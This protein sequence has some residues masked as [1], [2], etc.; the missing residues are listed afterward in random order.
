MKLNKCIHLALAVSF[1]FFATASSSAAETVDFEVFA[2]GTMLYSQVPGVLFSGKPLVETY[3][4]ASSGSRVLHTY[5]PGQEFHTGP[6]VI[7]FT[8][9]QDYV[10]LNAGLV[11]PSSIP[12]SATL[13]AYNSLGFVV[14]TD[15]A[16]VPVGPSDFN[17]QL[18][19]TTSTPQI[20][21]IELQY[22]GSLFEAIDDL[23]I[24]NQGPPAPQDNVAPQVTITD[25]VNGAVV[26]TEDFLF[27]ADILE[28]NLNFAE[29]T[30][31]HAGN[32]STFRVS[33][34]GPAPDHQVGPFWT[35]DLGIGSNTVT[36]TAVDLS[37]NTTNA[38]IQVERAAVEAELIVDTTIPWVIP[39]TPG[40]PEP[41]RVEVA[42]TFPG[43]LDGSTGITVEAVAPSMV[44][45][46]T[47]IHSPGDPGAFAD[48]ELRA[49]FQAPLGSTTVTLQAVDN[50]TGVVLDTVEIRASL[51][52]SN[53]P[54]CDDLSR[55]SYYQLVDRQELEDELN[56]TVDFKLTGLGVAV[57]DGAGIDPTIPTD[58]DAGMTLTEFTSREAFVDLDGDG[59]YSVF[60]PVYADADGSG[61]VNNPDQRLKHAPTSIVGSF[62]V[63]GDVD[64]G[65]LLTPFT[66]LH[67][68]VDL[69]N[70]GL[71]D[72][73]L[74]EP[75]Y[76][77]SANPAGIVS[78]G[79]LRMAD[80]LVA[81]PL[82]KKT[83][84]T[85]HYMDYA[86]TNDG[87]L[88]VSQEFWAIDGDS[89]ADVDFIGDL[90]IS[91]A[92]RDITFAYNYK[93][94]AITGWF[95]G[96]PVG[97]WHGS[98][99]EAEEQF[100]NDFALVLRDELGT[101]M[102]DRINEQQ[103]N[104]TTFLNDGYFTDTEFGLGFCLPGDAFPAGDD[105]PS[106]S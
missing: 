18:V 42:E 69:N 40:T 71:L 72:A 89:Q 24:S 39:R 38:V 37:G 80:P 91:V 84:M 62:V 63:S 25:P 47:S 41:L 94:I 67:Q 77:D 2:P 23:V 10:A 55:I 82:K 33:T 93:L 57:E 45:G 92:S 78:H 101:N 51:I 59:T 58:S 46:T 11:R 53:R 44:F 66:S 48:L 64:D 87:L 102:L 60:E 99:Q 95:L 68:Y 6:M 105:I 90:Q 96:I 14:N 106:D 17:Q 88:R 3:A 97:D 52:P 29:L 5:R 73:T 9:P 56:A 22:N 81:P 26:T 30:I 70:N 98:V 79:D 74:E 32:A 86:F 100:D 28:E 75:I 61:T 85:V 31:E 21:R 49:T 43:S 4:N 27:Q 34:T 19:V 15:T 16:T 36:L 103:A 104:S 65:D 1:L 12:A 54:E 7:R 13:R 8:A 83:D 35:G 76:E 20:T 50:A